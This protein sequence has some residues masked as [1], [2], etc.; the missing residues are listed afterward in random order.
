VD[1]LVELPLIFELETEICTGGG[2]ELPMP[3]PHQNGQAVLE[4]PVV[5]PDADLGFH[6][7]REGV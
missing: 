5:D 6:G 3:D 4:T 1:N 2:S 7:L